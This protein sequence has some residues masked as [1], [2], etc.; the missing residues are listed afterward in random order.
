MSVDYNALLYEKM[1]AEYTDFLNRLKEMPIEKVIEHAYEKVF[2]EDLVSCIECGN[3]EPNEAKALYLQKYP[4][5]YC[6]REWLDND[7]SYM[8]MLRDTIDDASKNAVKEMKEKSRE[9]R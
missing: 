8:D 6:Y 2:K 9:S 5:D 4:L 7:C 1:Q 3:L